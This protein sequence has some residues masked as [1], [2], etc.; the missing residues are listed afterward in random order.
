MNSWVNGKG[1]INLEKLT[2]GSLKG[3][4]A[5]GRLTMSNPTSILPYIVEDK[6]RKKQFT[7]DMEISALL[8]FSEARRRKPGI[9]DA[10]SEKISFISKLHYPMWVVP[11]KDSCLLVD[12]LGFFSYTFPYAKLPNPEIL[13]E[14]I[15]RTVNNKEQ[16]H[17]TLREHVQTFEKPGETPISLESIFAE[18]SIL[19]ILSKHLEQI[20]ASEGR[21]SEYVALLP[22]KLN[23]KDALEKAGKAVDLW[24]QT[25]SDIK[26][27]QYV[28]NVLDEEMSFEEEMILQEIEHVEA[29]YEDKIAP[30]R[31]VVEKKIE[32][33]LLKRDTRIAKIDK[34]VVRKLASRF[35]EKRRHE[36]E[37][38]S[39]E[40][41]LI[42]CN[43]KR[44]SAKSR[45]NDVSASKWEHKMKVYQSKLSETRD[46]LQSVSERIG[47]IR[48]QGEHEVWEVKS[49]CQLLIE[50]EKRK[51]LDLKAS[52]D[53]EIKSRK[54]QIEE[55]KIVTS[56]IVNQISRLIEL[57][58]SE[59]FKIREA[60]IPHR[61]EEITLL[62][63][64]FYLV[65]YEAKE[66]TRYLLLPPVLAM[67]FKGIVRKLQKAIHRFSLQSRIKLLLR[68]R[69]TALEKMLGKVL[70]EKI[71]KDST[72]EEAVNELG[73]SNN[74]LHSSGFK[75]ILTKGVEE[76]ESE[77][78]ILQEEK[79]ALLKTY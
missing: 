68:P 40:R 10:S 64:P 9:L 3:I 77:G 52:Q 39:L 63:L 56:G 79:E 48:K 36:R 21:R 19:S 44:K 27:L 66:K 51:I 55:M 71:R 60:T 73:V 58:R 30:L 42:D 2:T 12:G 33:L 57:K 17:N 78:W 45:G 13:T 46:N 69:S 47:Q 29:L 54:R 5:R 65:R 76:L 34:S 25:Q 41:N 37:L 72:L 32:K 28:I 61:S 4:Q 38:E 15:R 75:E 59:A 70:L 1:I 7:S 26:G 67:D 31:P 49:S 23:K 18:E 24:K 14:E 8:C 62:C 6:A 43:K 22:P 35:K 11:W 50:G 16:F 74:V 53:L 20:S